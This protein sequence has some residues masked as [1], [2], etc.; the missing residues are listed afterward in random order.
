MTD[1]TQPGCGENYC[2]ITGKNTGQ[3][4]QA[5]C[6]CLRVL[7]V[8]DRVALQKRI[9]GLENRI[10]NL[11]VYVAKTDD[12]HQ[13]FIDEIEWSLANSTPDGLWLSMEDRFN[14]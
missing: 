5:G 14:K 3:A 4:T 8:V 1:K 13:E 12:D 7:P 10:A 6:S 9:L 2:W 11:T